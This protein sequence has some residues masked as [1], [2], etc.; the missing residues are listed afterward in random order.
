MYFWQSTTVVRDYSFISFNANTSTSIFPGVRQIA[1]KDLTVIISMNY[2]FF[3]L[4]K[5]T[6]C[7]VT[8]WHPTPAWIWISSILNWFIS[9]LTQHRPSKGNTSLR[10][11]SCDVEGI[12]L[13]HWLWTET[14]TQISTNDGSTWKLQLVTSTARRRRQHSFLNTFTSITYVI[15][16]I[17]KKD[18]NTDQK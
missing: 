9:L 4:N 7:M 15:Q 11:K 17:D 8:F 12:D 1:S 16:P 5:T 2:P 6:C 14:Q 18:E 10:D 13:L 3:L